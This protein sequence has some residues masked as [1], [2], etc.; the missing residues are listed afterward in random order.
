MV[1]WENWERFLTLIIDCA[2]LTQSEKFIAAKDAKKAA[3]ETLQEII[4]LSNQ[5]INK[6]DKLDELGELGFIHTPYPDDVV[7]I[8]LKAGETAPRFSLYVEEAIRNATVSKRDE[9]YLPS[10]SN[11]I[12]VMANNY[13]EGSVEFSHHYEDIMK[14]TKFSPR[15]FC[16]FLR[17]K[18][19]EFIECGAL[20][21]NFKLSHEQIAGFCNAL[22][23]E[24]I[25]AENVKGYFAEDRRVKSR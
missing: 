17:D 3:E 14:T 11:F 4:A 20:P 7:G 19:D 16:V 22:F 24:S 8:L 12:R 15:L 18:I 6:I 13:E 10:L 2:S 23:E 1:T 5:L 21:K 9:R 25:G